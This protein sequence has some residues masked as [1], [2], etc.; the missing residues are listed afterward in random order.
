[1]E[2]KA[3]S[4]NDRQNEENELNKDRRS[5]IDLDIPLFFCISL[6]NESHP[7]LEQHKGE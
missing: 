2:K 3:D 4:T 7:A 1:M 6:E 5:Q